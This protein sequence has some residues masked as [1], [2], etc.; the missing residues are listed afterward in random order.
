MNGYIEEQALG[1]GNYGE[2]VLVRSVKSGQRFACKKIKLQGGGSQGDKVREESKNEVKAMAK[3][4]HPNVVGFIEAF[5]EKNVLH[6]VMEYCDGGDLEKLLLDTIKHK[7][8]LSEE[9][10]LSLFTQIALALRQLHKQHLLHRDLKSANVFLTSKGDVKLGDFG[11]SKQLTYTMALASTI[12]GTPYYFSP[13]LCQK[14]PYNNKSDVWS[15]GVILY[16]MINL[17]KPFEARNIQELRKRVVTEEPAPFDA[18][19]ISEDLKQLCLSMLRKSSS[20]RPSVEMV[21]QSSIIRAQMARMSSQLE[22]A[23]REARDR[24]QQIK[25]QHPPDAN[26]G[27][28]PQA[29]AV[30][31]PVPDMSLKTAGKFD[32]NQMRAMMQANDP[33]LLNVPKAPVSVEQPAEPVDRWHSRAVPDARSQVAGGVKNEVLE[34]FSDAKLVEQQSDFMRHEVDQL[35]ANPEPTDSEVFEAIGEA[36]TEEEQRLRD[37]L[38]AGKFITALQLMVAISNENGS[39][40][41]ETMYKEL[42]HLLGDQAYLVGELQRVSASFEAA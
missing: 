31:A 8:V 4:E 42:L 26:S 11:F 19:H 25:T 29:Q 41:A 24:A 35:L 16:E 39:P 6:I 22:K 10:I 34:D 28:L 14:L 2:C 38:G 20:T 9:R 18:P 17:R 27:K 3:I 1:A 13:E 37:A 33:T 21:L 12:C 23:S 7:K 32:P 40:Q 30:A 36:Q 5:V 15:L